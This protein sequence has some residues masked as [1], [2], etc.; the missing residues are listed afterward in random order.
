[1]SRTIILII[2]FTCAASTAACGYRYFCARF[3][4]RWW[5]IAV[6]GQQIAASMWLWL[7]FM[8]HGDYPAITLF[9]TAAAT[10]IWT[11]T[12]FRWCYNDEVHAQRTAIENRVSRLYETITPPAAAAKERK[13]DNDT[14]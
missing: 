1:M 11:D 7:A 12:A 10:A 6:T 4:S 3:T 14:N 2:L 13:T 9:G 5:W 8:S